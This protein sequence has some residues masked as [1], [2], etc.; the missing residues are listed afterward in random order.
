[1][2]LRNLS[3]KERKLVSD[4]ADLYK[5]MCE[6][7]ESEDMKFYWARE[8]RYIKRFS[9]LGFLDRN[10]M[11]T[12]I[13]AMENLD[14]NFGKFFALKSDVKYKDVYIVLPKMKEILQ[15]YYDK[16]GIKKEA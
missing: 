10:E 13:T 9:L 16:K 4:I 3:F 7:S 2:L 6:R 15:A 11:E 14:D 12:I 8:F 5:G 1:M